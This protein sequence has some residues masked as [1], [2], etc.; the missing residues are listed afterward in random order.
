M[1]EKILVL[2]DSIKSKGYEIEVV[3]K[4]PE[5]NIARLE[6]IPQANDTEME[7]LTKQLKYLVFY[8]S[9]DLKDSFDA[10]KDYLDKI[11]RLEYLAE[12][13]EY[14][15]EVEEIANYILGDKKPEENGE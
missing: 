8:K 11:E 3:D 13:G 1:K 2:I 7:K 10:L 5:Y 14:S 15:P 12:H 6:T 9:D 4:R